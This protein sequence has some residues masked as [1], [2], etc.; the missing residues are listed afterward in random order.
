MPAEAAA[1]AHAN[2]SVHA[3]IGPNAVLQAVEAL[4]LRI[5]DADTDALL[6]AS[7][8]RSLQRLPEEMVDEAEPRQLHQAIVDTLGWWAGLEV[9]EDAGLRTADYLLANRIPRPAQWLLKRLPAR[10]ALR[11]L[12]RSMSAHAWTFAGSGR[13]TYRGG[14]QPSFEIAGCPLCRGLHA[15]SPACRYY[16]AVFERLVRTLAARDARVEETGCEALGAPA[17]RFEVTLRPRSAPRRRSA[18]RRT[19]AASSAPGHAALRSVGAAQR[20]A[21]I[22]QHLRAGHVAR[23]R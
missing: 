9:L 6:R 5:G 14:R 15:Q 4:R 3:L 2:L 10:L 12:A 20:E 7:I 17:C 8:G 21:A 23:R 16:G 1:P 13:F 22:D 11:I 19:A 18:S